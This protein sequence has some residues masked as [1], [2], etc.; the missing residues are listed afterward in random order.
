MSCQVSALVC[1]GWDQGGGVVVYGWSG[2]AKYSVSVSAA[3][4][5]FYISAFSALVRLSAPP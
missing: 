5:K 3:P 1:H 4:V 2:I